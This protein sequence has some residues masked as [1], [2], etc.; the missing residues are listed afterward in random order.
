LALTLTAGIGLALAST[1]WVFVAPG[2]RSTRMVN[3]SV[4]MAFSALLIHQTHGMIEMHFAIFGLL[5]FLLFYR[6][7][8][9]TLVL[10]CSNA[11]EP[12][13]RRKGGAPPARCRFLHVVC[14]QPGPVTRDI[15]PLGPG[16]RTEQGNRIV[17]QPIGITE[18]FPSAHAVR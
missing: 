3:A 14:E 16:L 8:A 12:V 6:D 9:P 17:V 1:I 10:R 7:W 2:R 11:G 4:F 13:L 5:A 18:V 15:S